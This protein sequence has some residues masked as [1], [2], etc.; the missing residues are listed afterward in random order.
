LKYSVN[1]C[2]WDQP[3]THIIG[4]MIK[5]L[6]IDEIAALLDIARENGYEGDYD[7]FKY[8]LYNRPEV[9]P[10]PPSAGPDFSTGGLV[11]LGYLL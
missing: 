5:E 3:L 10:F 2:G 7:Q 6:F 11:S 9:I 8:D 4:A 1:I